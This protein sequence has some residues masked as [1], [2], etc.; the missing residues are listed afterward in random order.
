MIPYEEVNKRECEFSDLSRCA[1]SENITEQKNC[2]AFIMAFSEARC[3]FDVSDI[4]DFTPE[5]HEN[6]VAWNERKGN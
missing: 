1:C 4:C 5:K 6:V 3:V 2:K